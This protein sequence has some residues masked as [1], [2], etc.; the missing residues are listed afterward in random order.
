M[1]KEME[2]V[3]EKRIVELESKWETR[4]SQRLKNMEDHL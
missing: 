4:F 1:K 2:L 3:L